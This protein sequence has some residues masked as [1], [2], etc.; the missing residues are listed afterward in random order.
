MYGGNKRVQG[1]DNQT[2]A[3]SKPFRSVNAQLVPHFISY[4]SV[5]NRRIHATL[6]KNISIFDHS[7]QSSTAFSFGSLP[8]VLLKQSLPIRFFKCFADLILQMINEF[9]P[10]PACVPCLCFVYHVNELSVISD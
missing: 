5:D 8:F 10:F 1:M 3:S 4:M 6:F 2:K 9:N 7:C